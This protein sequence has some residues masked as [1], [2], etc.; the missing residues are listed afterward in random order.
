LSIW[1][2]QVAV[3]VHPTLAA[4]LV[5]EAIQLVRLLWFWEQITQLQLAAV[6]VE[7]QLVALMEAIVF[8]IL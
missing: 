4:V 6:E 2:S 8:F 3:E 1:L 7:V 5:Q